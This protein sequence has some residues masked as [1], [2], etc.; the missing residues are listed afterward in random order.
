[1]SFFFDGCC[2]KKGASQAARN[3]GWLVITLDID[4]K[5]KPDIC[6]DVRQFTYTGPRPDLMWFSP[7]CLEFSRSSLPW[8]QSTEP[9]DLS[10]VKACKRIIDET[11]PHYWIIENVKGAVPWFESILGQPRFVINPF[12]LWGYFPIPPRINLNSKQKQS[13]SSTR[14]EDRAV[15]PY[16]LSKAITIAAES[17][18]NFIDLL[19]AD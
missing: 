18:L 5:F 17:Q 10:I 15:I 13:F 7:P 9:P 8:I 4:P 19:T 2:G 12:Y 6:I 14:R 16:A 3:R 1:M 11:R